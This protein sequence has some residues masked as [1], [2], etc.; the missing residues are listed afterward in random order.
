MSDLQIGL[1][2]LGVL[3]IFLVLGF[4]WWQDRRLR[5]RMKAYFPASEHDPL[6]TT[7]E[8]GYQ[9]V[10]PT[11]AAASGESVNDLDEVDDAEEAD[12]VCEVVIEIAFPQPVS[13]A[14]LLPYVQELGRAGRK[15]VRIFAETDQRRHRA[16]LHPEELYASLQLAVLLANRSGALT[17]IEWSQAWNRA[18]DLAER[19]DAT[20]EGP[21]Q[22]SVLDQAAHL[23]EACAALDTQ[24][25]LT[26]LLDSPLSATEVMALARDLGFITDGRRLA[27]LA[28][29]G[30]PRFTLVRPD[31][32]AFDTG[33]DT[34]ACLYLLLDVPC[35]PADPHAFSHMVGVGRNLALS[36]GAQLVDDQG[37]P[38]A[39]G[40]ETSVDERLRVLFSQLEQ[41]GL[42][43][44]SARAQRVFA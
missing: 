25:G 32:A 43:A 23:D 27:W 29:S 17:A 3:L 1:I 34:I 6:L 31:G 16:R 18:Q 22:Q 44:G 19:F 37:K 10:L 9:D 35:S 21:E 26:L 40:A 36:L 38:L 15:P 11:L 14:E 42:T 2:V 41:V 5:R 28:D 20:I 24:V 7:E 30:V 4:N 13:G 33:A 8:A 12:P 39:E